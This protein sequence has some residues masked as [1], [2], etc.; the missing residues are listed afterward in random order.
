MYISK[1][2]I[3]NRKEGQIVLQGGGPES[4][5]ASVEPHLIDLI[6]AMAEM[7]RCLT[8]SEAIALANDLIIGTET[9]KRIVEWKKERNNFNE[10]SPVLGKKWWLLFKKRWSHRL[11]TKRGQKFA[12]DRSS[13]LTYKNVKEM[14]DDVYECMVECGVAKKLDKVSCEYQG[15][16]VTKYVLVWPVMCLVVDEVG[17]NI[18]QRGDGHVRGRKY[19]CEHRRSNR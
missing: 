16:L 1:F 10:N 18:S 8:T 13:A 19:C 9:E 2:T 17:S 4:L 11:V 7:R 15:N 14:Y 12:L 5:M 6:C 3:R